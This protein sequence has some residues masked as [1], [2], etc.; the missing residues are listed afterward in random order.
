MSIYKYDISN[1]AMPSRAAD[2]VRGPVRDAVAPILIGRPRASAHLRSNSSPMP[3]GFSTTDI[4]P[5][6]IVGPPFMRWLNRYPVQGG[7]RCRLS[8]NRREEDS[9]SFDDLVGAGEN[10][11]RGG[12]AERLGGREI[13]H[14]LKP[15]RLLDREVSGP[16]TSQYVVHE[17]RGPLKIL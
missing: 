9:C 5:R 8:W 4:G 10:R 14:E 17:G 16:C 2:L 11:W 13:D 1:T 12:Q 7:W 6:A 3:W 15:G